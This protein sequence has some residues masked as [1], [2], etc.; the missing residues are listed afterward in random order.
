MKRYRV[1]ERDKDRDVERERQTH[2]ER[3]IKSLRHIKMYICIVYNV[4]LC[5]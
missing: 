4:H 5:I 1:R 3:A 2:R